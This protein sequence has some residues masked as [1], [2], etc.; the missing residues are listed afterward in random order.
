MTDA[1]LNKLKDLGF[2]KSQKIKN[3]YHY[4][5]SIDKTLLVVTDKLYYYVSLPIPIIDENN[6]NILNK[7]MTYLRAVIDDLRSLK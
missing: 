6:L 1:Q 4:A 5:K 2:V 3:E 7:Y